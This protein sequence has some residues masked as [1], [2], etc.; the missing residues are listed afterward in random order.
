MENKRTKAIEKA[1]GG[2]DLKVGGDSR[3]HEIPMRRFKGVLADRPTALGS[4][5]GVAVPKTHTGWK[6]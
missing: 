3:T 2:K 4:I 5:Q 6:K 1:K